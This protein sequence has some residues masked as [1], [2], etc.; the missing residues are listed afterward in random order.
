M[1]TIIYYNTPVLRVVILFFLSLF[2]DATVI[3]ILKIVRFSFFPTGISSQ[4]IIGYAQ[5][6]G[7]PFYFDTIVFFIFLLIPLIVLLMSKY[8]FRS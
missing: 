4:Q 7:Y 8:F 2:L 5:Y 6:Y 1:G 3:F